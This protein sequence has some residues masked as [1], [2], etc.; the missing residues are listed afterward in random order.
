MRAYGR[1]LI[2]VIVNLL[3]NARQAIGEGQTW[4][5][6]SMGDYGCSW[7]FETMAKV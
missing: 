7:S 5:E 3:A 2:Q 1:Q 4:I 6:T